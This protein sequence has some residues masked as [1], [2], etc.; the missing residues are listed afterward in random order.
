MTITKTAARGAAILIGAALLLAPVQRA[1]AQTPEAARVDSIFA[2][3]ARPDGPGAAVAVLKDGEIV[4][5]QGYGSAQLEHG[6]PVT[7]ATIFHVASVSKQFTA[8]AIALLAERGALSL[9]D[10]VRTHIPELPDFGTPVTLRHLVHHTSGLRDQWELLAIAGWR[11]DDVITKEHILG[12]AARQR[13]LNFTPGSEYLYSN[14][15]YTLLAEVV[16]RVSGQPFRDFMQQHVFAPLGMTATHMHTDHEHIVPGRA[17]S[18]QGSAQAGW[19]NSVLSYANAGA[20]S[21]FTTAGDLA[22]WL[23]NYETGEVGGAG[24]LARMYE[25]GVL[26]NGDTIPYAFAIVRGTHAG[27]TTW[28]HGGADAGFRSAVFYFP[29]ERL[30]VVVL[31]NASSFGAGTLAMAVADVY[32]DAARAGAAAPSPANST[33]VATP[34]RNVPVPTHVLDSYEGRWEIDSLGIFRFRRD[35]GTLVVDLGERV[36]PMVA[37]SDTTFRVEGA[38]IRFVRAGDRVDELVASGSEGILRGRRL[39]P[40]ALTAAELAELTGDYYSPELET[41]YR[42]RVDDG[43]LAAHHVRHGRIVLR[44]VS[45]DRFTG[46]RW[47]FG[48][49]QFERD[50]AGRIAG[51]RVSGG[52][53]RDLWFLRLPDGVLP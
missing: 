35:G 47:F 44:P 24:V 6:V 50:S 5:E 22:R 48:R 11:L 2:A 4:L 53:V 3:W 45:G 15:G 28:S 40:A 17:Y 12:L 32:L 39:S 14:M 41:I 21:L 23:R 25:R 34:P 18:Y 10:D 27:R 30:G 37:L 7:P 52:R 43:V 31:G 42:I 46:N 36:L 16:E 26:G 8:F 9:D 1:A 13:A 19:R 33:A 20:T 38:V 49:L 29:D 51:F